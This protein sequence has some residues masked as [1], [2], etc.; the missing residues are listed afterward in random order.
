MNKFLTI[1][2]IALLVLAGGYYLVKGTKSSTAPGTSITDETELETEDQVMEKQ[3]ESNEA[4]ETAETDE[5]EQEEN[6]SEEDSDVR[7]VKLEASNYK[8]DIKEIV[9]KKGTKIKINLVSKQ[10]THDLVINEFDARTKQINEEDSDS[11]EFIADKSGT[12]EYYC[13]V[14]QHRQMGMVGK[15]IVE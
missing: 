5:S 2:I 10:G 1:F 8:Y 14:G 9:V 11:I 3:E 7:T 13:S 15:L 4:E 6:Q 12:F